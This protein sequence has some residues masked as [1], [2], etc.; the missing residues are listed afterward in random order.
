MR[1][2]EAAVKE[3]QQNDEA[4]RWADQVR[5]NVGALKGLGEYHADLDA[6]RV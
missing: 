3:I 4:R 5:G 2:A 1:Q 6:V